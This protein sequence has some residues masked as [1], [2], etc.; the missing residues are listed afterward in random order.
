MKKNAF[1]YI[2]V[3]TLLAFGCGQKTIIEEIQ[4]PE[5]NE[6][7]FFID[8]NSDSPIRIRF[9][10]SMSDSLEADYYTKEGKDT[11]TIPIYQPEVILISHKSIYSDTLYVT[12]GDSISIRLPKSGEAFQL[13][14]GRKSI[15][16]SGTSQAYLDSLYNLYI[17]TN[18]EFKPL[19]IK[20]DFER[21]NLGLPMTLNKALLD[22]NP[23]SFNLLV[24][25]LL[26]KLSEQ[27][28]TQEGTS[29]SSD[30]NEL[31]L[32]LEKRK[33]FYR[34]MSLLRWTKSQEIKDRAFASTMFTDESIINSRFGLGYFQNFIIQIVLEGKTDRS[35]SME[36]INFK[37][38]YDRLPNHIPEGELLKIAR[39]RSL[40]Q[41][42]EYK[43][44]YGEISDYL[45]E[46]MMTYKDSTFLE[47]FTEQFLLG[48]EKQVNEKVGLNLLKEDGSVIRFQDILIKNKGKVIYVDYWASWCSPCIEAMPY[49]EKLREEYAGQNIIFVYLS[50]DNDQSDWKK[51][52][53]RY[54]LS[55]LENN[56]LS[57]NHKN[58]DWVKNLKIQ[59]IPRYLI[60]D[61]H[62]KLVEADAPGP[63]D[64]SIKTLLEKYIYAQD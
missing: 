50:S 47:E 7:T 3:I 36:Y 20:A 46:Y 48:Y 31:K 17:S 34:L 15:S 41:M 38:A 60:F 1:A 12:K 32:D 33:A 18:S 54:D 25:G 27:R 5:K 11:L 2:L 26:N 21:I 35:R 44:P 28:I 9:Y 6:V 63:K 49:A 23:D 42:V 58:S 57:L 10:R 24:E 8:N 39:E 64:P 29:G 59:S 22:T 14:G 4:A 30:W 43:E 19:E 55:D 56:Y 53:E 51:A 13:I 37:E 52:V 61:T 40:Y 45:N 16:E 62:G